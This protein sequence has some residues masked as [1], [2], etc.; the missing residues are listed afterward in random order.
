MPTGGIGNPDEVRANLE[1]FEDVGVDQVVFIQQGGKNRHEDICSSLELF[2]D[3]VMPGLQ[4][5]ARRPRAEE[6]G[7]AR[8]VRRE[9]DGA[10]P[11]AR[12]DARGAEP[13]ESYPVLMSRLGVDISQLPNQRRMGPAAATVK[14]ATDAER[15]PAR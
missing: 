14:G 11:A 1:K 7:G 5:A 13:I 10:H 15:P 3:R 4:G 9:G 6:G 2:A 8:A 12:A